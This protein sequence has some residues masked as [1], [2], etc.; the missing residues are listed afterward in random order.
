MTINGGERLG[1][2]VL[3]ALLY[4]LIDALL[5]VLLFVYLIPLAIDQLL[6]TVGG[7]LEEVTGINLEEA[8]VGVLPLFIGIYAAARALKG[9][10]YSAI[11]RGLGSLIAFYLILYFSNAGIID[12]RGVSIDGMQLDFYLDLTPLLVIVLLFATLPGVVTPFIEY[13]IEEENR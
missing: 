11:L 9:T 1:S 13:L 8:T 4:A 6:R 2:R 3:R 12:V 10:I 7:G 5:I